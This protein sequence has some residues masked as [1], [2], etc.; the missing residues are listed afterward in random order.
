MGLKTCKDCNNE[1]STSAGSCPHCGDSWIWKELTSIIY[2]I[3]GNG[4]LSI[5][6]ECAALPYLN[7][8]KIACVLDQYNW[9]NEAITMVEKAISE[10]NRCL[11]INRLDTLLERV[12][13]P[14]VG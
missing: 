9:R 3:N 6:T 12:T 10:R 14:K 13:P 11:A 5:C 8:K 1:I 7:I 4:G 2:D